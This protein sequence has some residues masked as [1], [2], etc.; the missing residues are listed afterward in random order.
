VR[1]EV[2]G[3]LYA[4]IRERYVHAGGELAKIAGAVAYRSGDLLGA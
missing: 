2:D 3:V 1:A 4:R